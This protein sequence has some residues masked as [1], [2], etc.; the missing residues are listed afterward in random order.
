MASGPQGRRDSRVGFHEVLSICPLFPIFG[1]LALEY[2]LTQL[3][4][5]R[6]FMAPE[7]EKEELVVVRRGRETAWRP[8]NI[9]EWELERVGENGAGGGETQ[10]VR[11]KRGG[12]VQEI[13]RGYRDEERW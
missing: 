8:I 10:R 11:K 2:R 12:G 9:G 6:K 1:P 4:A 5:G 7:G 13:N 3:Q